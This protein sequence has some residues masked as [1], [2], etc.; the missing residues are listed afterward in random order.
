MIFAIGQLAKDHS[1]SL[2][3][4]SNFLK[5]KL[6]CA[7]ISAELIYSAEVVLKTT[8]RALKWV[9][10]WATSRL[11]S[12]PS[13]LWRRKKKNP[14]KV[15]HKSEQK[16]VRNKSPVSR[17]STFQVAQ[18]HNKVH[19]GGGLRL[20]QE[21]TLHP[22]F[23]EVPQHTIQI[24][25]SCLELYY[26][27]YNYANERAGQSNDTHCNS[28]ITA[29]KGHVPTSR[30]NIAYSV[31]SLHGKSSQTQNGH[32]DCLCG[33]TPQI[34]PVVFLLQAEFYV[35]WDQ[36][37]KEM[38]NKCLIPIN[39]NTTHHC[40]HI[41]VLTRGL[42]LRLLISYIYGAPSKVRNA[43]VVYISTYV[44]QRWNS[45]FIFA[46]QCFNTESM[47]RGFLCHICV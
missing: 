24:V 17:T 27:Q 3:E 23:Q 8:V 43:N 2:T 34:Q 22:A 28:G 25:R 7:A 10:L 16:P 33:S 32:H 45:L 26:S 4:N 37:L 30:W 41:H 47:Q 29:G 35:S 39:V 9:E 21:R 5:L 46:A 40:V 13:F 1:C 44:W 15:A 11:F 14:L 31:R 6:L 38:Y 36:I 42:T 12:T 20:M 19:N 18:T